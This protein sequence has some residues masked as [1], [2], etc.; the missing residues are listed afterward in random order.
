MTLP[1]GPPHP[2]RAAGGPSRA[3]RA[4]VVDPRLL[5]HAT[6]ARGHLLTVAALG[7]AAAALILA[8]AGLLA[9][10]L[11]FVLLRR[12]VFRRGA[13]QRAGGSAAGHVTRMGTGADTS[14]LG[15]RPPS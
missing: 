7:L 15:G 10:V 13:P 5:S 4:R 6:A 3:W 11:R 12:W 9:T 2:P 1:S 14:T 8:Q